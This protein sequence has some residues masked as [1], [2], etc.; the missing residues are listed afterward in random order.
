M[1]NRRTLPSHRVYG[2]RF[3]AA[4]HEA[5]ERSRGWCQFCGY[6]RATEAHHW[7]GT[8]NAGPYPIDDLVKA[9]DLTALCKRCHETAGEIRK[10][11]RARLERMDK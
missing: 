9:S 2:P 10:Q 7:S 8:I 4:R 6:M 11:E 5:I 3:T 1:I